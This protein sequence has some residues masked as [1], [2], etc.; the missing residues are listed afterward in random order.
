MNREPLLTTGAIVAL[1]A[2]VLAFLKSLGV[3][4]SDDTQEALRNV[5]AILAPVVLAFVA[6]QFVYSPN[7]VSNIADTQYAAGTPPTDPQP[8]IPPPAE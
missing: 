6:R 7:S 1:V 2:A 5:V 8:P 4:I 3:D